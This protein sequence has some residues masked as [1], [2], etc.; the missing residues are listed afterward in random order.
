MRIFILFLCLLH[1][2]AYGEETLT[3]KI[4]KYE[5]DI[6]EKTKEI[7]RLSSSIKK[8]EEKLKE[9]KREKNVLKSEV[10][11]LDYSIKNFEK[12]IQNIEK[13]S[14]RKRI[15]CDELK[16]ESAVLQ[17]KEKSLK[18]CY[19]LAL[20]L[21]SIKSILRTSP[22]LKEE[23]WQK[24]VAFHNLLCFLKASTSTL[25]KY[26]K[27]YE[28]LIAEIEKEKKGLSMLAEKKKKTE[29]S[30]LET[31]KMQ[32]KLE[33]KLLSIAKNEDI[34]RKEIEELR[35]KEERLNKL[36]SSL[37]KEKEV[38]E[39][40][41]FEVNVFARM[42][43]KLPWPVESKEILRTFGTYQHPKFNAIMVSKGIK[44]LTEEGTKVHAVFDGD[45]VFAQEF[46]RYGKMLIIRHGVDYYTLYAN[47]KKMFVKE[48]DSVKS[49]QLI[50][51]AGEYLDFQIR[52]G[53]EAL[54]PL[55]WLS[56]GGGR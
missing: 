6:K 42:K 37:M 26:R 40:A 54:D 28:F 19:A 7:K 48:G 43:G 38:T 44:I 49:R 15:R 39:K 14:L 27:N 35:I 22:S 32:N 45:V 23:A 25:L 24:E 50:A 8:K 12:Q 9:L 10:E 18:E 46:G 5:K 21:F 53:M 29:I 3:Q 13:E 16:K 11:K 20:S 2:P 51:E 30:L 52:K 55:V 41:F 1:I 56:E 36:I 17:K 34:I 33:E 31:K 47:L 4:M